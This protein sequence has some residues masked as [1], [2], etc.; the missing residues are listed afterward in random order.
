M[1]MKIMMFRLLGLINMVIGIVKGTAKSQGWRNS[2]RTWSGHVLVIESVRARSQE[3]LRL[4][5]FLLKTNP[6]QLL[7]LSHRHGRRQLLSLEKVLL[8]LLLMRVNI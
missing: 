6:Q 5:Q 8:L 3:I 1:M 4:I 2:I 7:L